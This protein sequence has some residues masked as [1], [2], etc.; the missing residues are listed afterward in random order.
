MLEV[1]RAMPYS[2]SSPASRSERSGSKS[3]S[4]FSVAVMSAGVSSGWTQSWA[5]STM[6]RR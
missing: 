4:T 5:E 1:Q 6:G 3:L 2:P